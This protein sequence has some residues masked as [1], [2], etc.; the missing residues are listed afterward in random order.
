MRV[1]EFSPTTDGWRWRASHGSSSM[2]TGA[3]MAALAVSVMAALAVS[4]RVRAC[5]GVSPRPM[6]LL[7]LPIRAAFSR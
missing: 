1:V 3:S 5:D 6:L 2:A 7:L 4:V